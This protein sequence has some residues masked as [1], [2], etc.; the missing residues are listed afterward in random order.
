L[1]S[2]RRLLRQFVARQLDKGGTGVV[3]IVGRQAGSAGNL[4]LTPRFSEVAGASSLLRLQN[5]R[6]NFTPV[7]VRVLICPDKFKGT[8]AAV[9]AAAAI[10]R[11]WRRARPDDRQTVLPISDGGDGFGDV[12]GRLLR[13]RMETVRTIDAAHRPLN[14][15]WWW[16]P[17]SKSAIIEAAAVIGLA[18]LP[19]KKFHPFELD[20]AGVAT[21][22]RAA[23]QRGAKRCVV[24]VGGS[25]TNDGGF[26]LARALGW[27]FLTRRGTSIERWT[28]LIDLTC[29]VAP[30]RVH[31]FDELIVAVDVQNPLL[32]VRGATRVYGPQKGLRPDDLI[33]AEACLRRLAK[34]LASRLTQCSGHGIES[35]P[36]SR[37]QSYPGSGAA[38]GLAFG[39]VTFAGARLTPGFELI[40]QCSHLEKKLRC[41]D[42]V[43]TGEGRV[44]RSTLMGKGVGELAERCRRRGIPCI[45]LAGVCEDHAAV[46]GFFT[47]IRSLTELVPPG[48]AQRQPALWLERLAERAATRPRHLDS[49][50]TPK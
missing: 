33:P 27:K 40:A 2:D 13:A 20:T 19:A 6:L 4:T 26:G 8:L 24:G 16:E 36:S 12:F 21:V 23:A 15:T 50:R 30:R 31:L 37:P 39:L 42:L 48:T 29:V 46:R 34:V 41:A 45:A 5:R 3:E 11:G 7:A 1:N 22:L 38:G 17:E 32:G 18:L 35:L 28:R 25:A 44:D 47:E 10:A 49:T 14:A 43:I 9:D